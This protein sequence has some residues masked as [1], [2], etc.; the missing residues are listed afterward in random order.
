MKKRVLSTLFVSLF[1]SV[2]ALAQSDSIVVGYL[3]SGIQCVKKGEYEKSIDIFNE[4]LKS[5]LMMYPDSSMAVIACKS[6][7]ANSYFRLNDAETALGLFKTVANYQRNAY[8]EDSNEYVAQLDHIAVCYASIDAFSQAADYF[9]LEAN[10]YRKQFDASNYISALNSAILCYSHGESYDKAF[11]TAQDLCDAL[12]GIQNEERVRIVEQ[13]SDDLNLSAKIVRSI[14]CLY[15]ERKRSKECIDAGVLYMRLAKIL[16]GE[17]SQ[18]YVDGLSNMVSFYCHSGNYSQAIRCGEMSMSIAERLQVDDYSAGYVF[19]HIAKTLEEL[20]EYEKQLEFLNKSLEKF[21]VDSFPSEHSSVLSNIG[22]FYFRKKDYH[23]ALEYASRAMEIRKSIDEGNNSNYIFS[24]IN[25]AKIY[26]EIGE[27]AKAQELDE[28]ALRISE[29]L[30]G[31]LSDSYISSLHS[32]AEDYHYMEMP[33]KEIET[34]LRVL[35][36]SLGVYDCGAPEIIRAYFNLADEYYQSL[37]YDKAVPYITRYFDLQRESIFSSIENLNVGYRQ[38]FWEKNCEQLERATHFAIQLSDRR[39][40]ACVAYNSILFMKGLLLAS[41]QECRKN[42]KS[43]QIESFDDSSNET[44][45]PSA[46][47]IEWDDVRNCLQDRDV[48]VEFFLDDYYGYDAYC[49]MVLRKEWSEPKVEY[50]CNKEF[51][52]RLNCMGSKMFSSPFSDLGYEGVWLPLEK[53]ISSGDRVYF[54][55]DCLMQQIN[56]ELFGISKQGSITSG[57]DLVRLSS[58]RDICRKPKVFDLRFA[59]IYGGL[60]YDVGGVSEHNRNIYDGEL[61]SSENIVN[62]IFPH[63]EKYVDVK[64]EYLPYTSLEADSINDLLESGNVSTVLYKGEN[65]TE[66]SLKALSGRECSVLHIATHGFF[67]DNMHQSSRDYSHFYELDNSPMSDPMV[68][69]GLVM[70]GGAAQRY[71][72]GASGDDDGILF[73]KEISE[74]DL[75]QVDIVVLSACNTGLGEV[76]NDGVYGLQRAFKLAGVKTIIMSL[77]NIEDSVT[78]VFMNYLYKNLLQG[79]PIHESFRGA[80]KELRSQYPNPYYWASF[81]M[82]D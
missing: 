69:S 60:V 25:T 55:T 23:T 19:G 13:Y 22:S 58:T 56:V 2:C 76:K 10:V 75:S 4:A 64:W 61:N 9:V 32:I 36:L 62:G 35:D 3:K 33:D 45:Y 39:D 51:I 12:Y 48:A 57:C 18:E 71:I 26:R 63:S 14:S 27:Y 74:L 29:E 30:Y 42:V 43:S 44:S 1:A 77:W 66:A 52:E 38:S 79:L 17:T 49:A 40:M 80:Q 5:S 16:Y 47:E 28:Q 65:G 54:S 31:E 59:V 50:V 8:G 6:Q 82:L 70:S 20:G 67:L 11:E 46:L 7:L 21:P 34:D 53:Y 68:R 73:S 41:E 37:Q 24:L 15:D 72:C 78:C 81:I